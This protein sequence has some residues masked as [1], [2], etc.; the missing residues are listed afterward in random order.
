MMGN[1]HSAEMAVW[2]VK[3]LKSAINAM[4]EW[5]ETLAHASLDGLEQR[6]NT[7]GTGCFFFFLSFS[8]SFLCT[9]REEIGW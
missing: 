3:L 2:N 5:K 4:M 9:D 6:R 8:S 7:R 1:V